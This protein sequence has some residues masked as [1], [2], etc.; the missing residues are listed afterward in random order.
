MEDLIA[1]LPL[2]GAVVVFDL[3]W[4]AWEGSQARG[5]NGPGEHM[6]IVQIGAVKL[7]GGLG[8]KETGGFETL[9]RPCINPDLSDYFTALTGIT[10]AMVERNGVGFPAALKDFHRFVGSDTDMVLSFGKDPDVL[11]LNC[12]MNDIENPFAPSVFG[13]VVPAFRSALGIGGGEFSSSD[14]P[15][16]MDFAPP[17][18]AHDAIGDSRC[19][20]EALRRLRRGDPGKA[21]AR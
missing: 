6:E 11:A 1:A 7:D 14:L 15:R 10:P 9:V 19:I 18:A 2:D 3:E 13:N 5:W 17:G 8:L 20:A 12:R 4:T 21:K 16:L